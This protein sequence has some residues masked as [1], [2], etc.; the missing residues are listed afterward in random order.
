MA[1]KFYVTTAIDY[2]N[3]EPHIGHAYQKI[4]ADVLARWNKLQ[5]KEVLFATG[6]DEHGKKVEDAAK[7]AG[8]DPKEFV[9]EVSKKFKEAWKALN[10]NYDRFVRTTDK[11]HQEVVADVIKKCELNG[12][13]Y[14][15]EYEGFYC[16]GCEAYYTEKDCPDLVCPLH[17]KPLE[18]IKEETYFFKLSKYQDFLLDLY[19]EHPEFILPKK[20]RNET[21]SR[22]KEGLRDLS[23]TRTSFDWGIP[24]PLDKKHVTYV[25]F[26]ALINY[27]TATQEKGREKFWGK[28]TVHLLGKD[29]T[30]F[31]TVYWPAM[32]KSAGIELPKTTFNHGFLSFNGQKI[33]KSLGNTISPVTLVKKY[34]AD[35]VRYFC[36]RQFPFASGD[37]GDF[38]ETALVQRHNDELANKLG[39][40]VSRTSA[41]A[42]KYGITKTP[43]TL[44]KKL[45]VKQIEKLVDN[46]ELDK[47]LNEIFAFIDICNEF[48]QSKKPWETHDKKVLFQLVESI[49]EIAKILSP[50][51]PESAEKISEVFKTD[52]I[53]KAPVLFQKIEVSKPN[54]NKSEEPKEIMEG[55]TTIQYADFE[56][57][58]I[59]VA[60]IQNVED[61]EGADKLYK[62]D[63]SIGDESRVICAGIKEFYSHDDLKGK[64]IIVLTNLAPRKLRGIES[65]G[66][67]LAAS[68]PDHTSVSLITPDVDIEAGS[69]VG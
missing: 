8:K 60:E 37:D 25:W 21:I 1:E 17:K 28:P 2:V 52:D 45:K 12:D 38:S 69:I 30:W 53:K 15:G 4:V 56:K 57:L 65:E 62:L 3:A 42:E 22:V 36:L 66:M 58:D 29:N 24:F 19:K 64:K 47:A 32:L 14:L 39:N 9:D 7:K 68:N 44:L 46:F 10:I 5:G 34:G 50:F 33:S 11:D 16:T 27:Y 20:R 67:L 49:R 41:L 6:T 61:I 18:K 63:I 54:L 40:L 59:R 26:D 13:I 43:N 31:H 35:S 48:I 55:V 51:I 23:I